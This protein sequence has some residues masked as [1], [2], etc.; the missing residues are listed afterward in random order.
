GLANRTTLDLWRSAREAAERVG[1][2]AERRGRRAAGAV[3]AVGPTEAA[4]RLAD[5]TARQLS[6][7]GRR[8]PAR[9]GRR[10]GGR[11]R[12]RRVRGDRRGRT[13]LQVVADDVEVDPFGRGLRHVRGLIRAA[14]RVLHVWVRLRAVGAQPVAEVAARL[15]IEA[16]DARRATV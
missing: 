11:R 3:A 7:L 16:D 15:L 9:G 14:E 10:V 1:V 4:A 6:R 8:P 5:R 2:V 12:A 13:C